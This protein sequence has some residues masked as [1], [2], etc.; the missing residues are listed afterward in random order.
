MTLWTRRG[1]RNTTAG[2]TVVTAKT[3]SWGLLRRPMEPLTSDRSWRSALMPP[4]SID[5]S[6]PIV[7]SSK[8]SA[9]ACG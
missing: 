1:G 3:Y 4:P 8:V 5:V 7:S 2:A 6:V 9:R